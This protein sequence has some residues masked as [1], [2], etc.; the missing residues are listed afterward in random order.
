MTEDIKGKRFVV[1]YSG[2]LDS[3]IL[4]KFLESQGCYREAVTIDYGQRHGM[5]EI[6]AAQEIT[7]L[8]NVAHHVVDVSNLGHLIKGNSQTDASVAVP[9]GHYTDESMKATVVPNRNM[10]M[11][12]IAMARAIA[13]DMDGVAYAAHAGDHPIYPD[14]RPEFIEAMR[15]VFRRCH[16]RPMLLEAPFSS[17]TKSQLVKMSTGL[18]MDDLLGKTW[19]CYNG[20]ALHCGKC[21][22]CVERREAFADAEVTDP[23]VYE[24]PS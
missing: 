4:L 12:S 20:R 17:L 5:A 18:G 3:T 19:S 15:Q 16:D 21:G 24:A 7:H 2:G 22:T 13:E 9:E 11:L 23:T 10:V 14:C 1:V 6:R 8:M